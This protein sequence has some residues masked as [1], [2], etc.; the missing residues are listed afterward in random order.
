MELVE[1]LQK[2]TTAEIIQHLGLCFITN[3]TG[4]RNTAVMFTYTTGDYN[5]AIGYNSL[6]RSTN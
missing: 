2:L 5:V 3:T 4:T 6:K 1:Q